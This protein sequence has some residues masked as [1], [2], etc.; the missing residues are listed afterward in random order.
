MDEVV[1]VAAG[2]SA[3]GTFNGSLASLSATDIATQLVPQVL[4][5]YEVN[6]AEIDEI[7]L[8]QVLTAGCGQNTAR[9]VGIKSGLDQTVPALTIN[10]VCGSGLKAVQL[11]ANAIQV[12]DASVVLLD[13]MALQTAVGAV[14][15]G[16]LASVY[17]W[18]KA[19]NSTSTS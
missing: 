1:I 7:I 18:L 3:I 19:A 17:R 6:P 15:N 8:G 4:S 12:G 14:D 5:S 13:T 9:Q 10:K 11:A 16:Q 2:R